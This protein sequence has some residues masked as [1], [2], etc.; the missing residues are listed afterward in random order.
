MG[1]KLY[2]RIPDKPTPEEI[3]RTRKVKVILK[4]L[5]KNRKQIKET[6]E[7]NENQYKFTKIIKPITLVQDDKK[8]AGNGGSGE[9][10][11]EKIPLV[12]YSQLRTRFASRLGDKTLKKYSNRV[13]GQILFFLFDWVVGRSGVL[14]PGV[15]TSGWTS[16]RTASRASG[17]MVVSS[18]RVVS[19][20]EKKS[21]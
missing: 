17:R 8:S 14:W 2:N 13:S 5:D 6:C 10:L 4:K 19:G 15:R 3:E 18:A 1:N 9:N 11:N 16:G 12:S 20:S 7:F 21:I